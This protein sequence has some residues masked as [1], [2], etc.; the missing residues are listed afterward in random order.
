M[1]R[2]VLRP[3]CHFR[4]AI[5]DLRCA[6]LHAHCPD[7]LDVFKGGRKPEIAHRKGKIGMG[8]RLSCREFGQERSQQ[9]SKC[10]QKTDGPKQRMNEKEQEQ[11]YGRPGNVKKSE[12]AGESRNWRNA[13]R[14]L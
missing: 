4:I 3:S 12:L 14:S 1:H 10:A 7:D 9:K 2:D 5:D 13:A 6:I 11:E 8:K